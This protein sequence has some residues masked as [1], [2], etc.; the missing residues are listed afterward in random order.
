MSASKT[1]R[2]AIKAAGGLGSVTDLARRWGVSRQRLSQLVGEDDFPKPVCEVNGRPVYLVGE[3]DEWRQARP[4]TGS[5][6]GRPPK[7]KVA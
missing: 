6:G 7:E 2:A 5:A 4:R 3:C 1:I